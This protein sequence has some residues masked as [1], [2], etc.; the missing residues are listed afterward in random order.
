MVRVGLMMGL[1]CGGAG[2][3]VLGPDGNVWVYIDNA[4][5]KPMVVA[6]DGN[7]EVTIA[8]GEFEKLTLPPGE[9]RF[10]IQCGDKVVFD[11]TKDLQTS[12]HVGVGRRYLF[13]PDNRHRY[14]TYE[15]KYGS[16]PVEGLVKSWLEG[17]PEDRQSARRS[18]YKKI[19]AQVKLLP[20]DPWFEV[21]GGAYVLT[22]PP[23]VVMTRGYTERR[24]VMARVARKDFKFLE[25]AAKNANPTEE[26]LDELEEVVERILSSDP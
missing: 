26:D 17:P 4:G 24:T 8:S 2:C 18:A 7:E 20:A 22:P 23:E 13:N 15:V 11:G 12:E 3:G 19:A 21:P 16:S 25:S 1:V 9:K 5:K 6:V 10:H 14:V